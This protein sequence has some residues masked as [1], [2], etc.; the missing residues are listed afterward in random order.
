M[1]KC[2][3]IS[4]VIIERSI[5][6][7]TFG[8]V[9]FEFGGPYCCMIVYNYLSIHLQDEPRGIFSLAGNI[10]GQINS[11]FKSKPFLNP[12]EQTQKFH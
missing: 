12:Q 5:H 1:K 9:C 3:K 2:M 7:Y 10:A 8:V 6:M 11:F 4:T